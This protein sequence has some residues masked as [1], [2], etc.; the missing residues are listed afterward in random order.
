MHKGILY[1]IAAP[2]GNLGDIT[3][4]A[5]SILREVGAVAA[6]DTRVARRLLSA[7]GARGKRV[8]CARAHVENRAARAVIAAAA[9]DGC[10]YL[11]D[12]GT[13]AISDPGARL[14]AAARAAGVAVRPVPGPSALTAALSAAGIWRG[15][16][17]FCFFGFAPRAA[18]ARA[19][20]FR[21]LGERE[22]TSVFF[23]SPRTAA[24]AAAHMAAAEEEMTAANGD[25]DG[26]ALLRVAVCRELTKAHEQIEVG[27]AREIERRFADGK[28]PARG[29]FVFAAAAENY[30]A[31]IAAPKSGAEICAILRAELPPRRAAALTAKIAGGRARDWYRGEAE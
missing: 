16:G 4:R 1:M 5:L 29:E 9:A 25:G 19:R 23:E 15:E 31:K 10:A 20:F 11:C 22:E 21:G 2:I 8:I 30:R 12:A 14:A 28:I 24:N 18:A 13:P 3:L 6:E 17:R 7:H 27:G 26:E